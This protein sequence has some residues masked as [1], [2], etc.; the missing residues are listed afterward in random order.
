MPYRSLLMLPSTHD[1]D[2][3]GEIAPTYSTA[4]PEPVNGR[5]VLDA[6]KVAADD[7]EEADEIAPTVASAAPEP[8][9]R[10]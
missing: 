10:R 2:E 9:N 6:D 8:V 5:C 1:D 4:A 3:A 7:D